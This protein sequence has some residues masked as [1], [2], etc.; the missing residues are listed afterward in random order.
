MA[1]TTPSQATPAATAAAKPDIS[2]AGNVTLT[3]LG[4]G[5]PRRPAGADR[6]AQQAVRWR[7]TRTSRS[8]G[9]RSRSRTRSRRSSSAA[10][11]PNA[12]DIVPANQG[13]GDRWASWSR[14]SCCARS[15]DY[16]KVYGWE[17][18]Y[19]STLLDLNKFSPD[20][21]E[22]GSG[23]LYGLSQ[24][25]EIVGVF[26][27]KEKVADAADDAGRVRGV[28]GG[29][30]GR[31]RDA[32]PCSATRRSGRASTTSR[33]C[34]AR[35]PT[36]RRCATSCSRR[37][38]RRSTRRSSRPVPRSSRSGSTR[39]TSTRTSTA[40]T[41]TRRGQTSRRARAAT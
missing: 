4:P 34:S 16:A 6:G 22:F 1:T 24:M 40:S 10:S 19:S 31:G 5:C 33:A 26:Y 14:P 18:R 12:P 30:Q 36:S 15:T 41:T 25:G 32:D 29:G 17:D 11:D 13:R 9:S 2:K 37:R 3:D 20:G 39:A 21:K 38:A 23:E 35:R 7:S 28:A 8:S 27:N